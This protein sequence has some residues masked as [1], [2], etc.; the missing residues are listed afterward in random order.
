VA[1]DGA[2]G[3]ARGELGQRGLQPHQ[4]A[5]LAEGHAGIGEEGP[6][7]GPPAG[8]GLPAPLGQGPPVRGVGEQPRRHRRGALVFGLP[9]LD[10]G[11]RHRVQQ[12][13]EQSLGPGAL[14]G[15]E[16]VV[17]QIADELGQQGSDRDRH[18]ARPVGR[19]AVR[20]QVQRAHRGGPGGERLMP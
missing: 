9:D 2:D 12:I 10:G 17:A 1:G 8:T 16:G 14:P 7:Q 4:A 11:H 6:G 13:A 5:P 19:G 20:A 15:T 18:R 3:M